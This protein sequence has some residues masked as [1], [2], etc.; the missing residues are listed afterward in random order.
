M[1]NVS[2]KIVGK[3]NTDMLFSKTYDPPLLLS[4]L[5]LLNLLAPEL[6]F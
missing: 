2:D 5:A 3:I 4:R 6:F 1:K